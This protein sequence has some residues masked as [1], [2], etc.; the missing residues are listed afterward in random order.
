MPV[1]SW[2]VLRFIMSDGISILQISPRPKTFRQANN[3]RLHKRLVGVV[4]KKFSKFVNID[5]AYNF[6]E[7]RV[8]TNCFIGG[9]VIKLR[10]GGTRE[11]I[12]K[13]GVL[14]SRTDGAIYSTPD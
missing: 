2:W 5:I 13:K 6:E 10:G 7:M 1:I 9:N 3:D 11:W 12:R 14:G 8:V 4:H